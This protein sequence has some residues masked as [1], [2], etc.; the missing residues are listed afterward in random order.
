MRFHLLT[1]GCPKNEVDSEGMIK[2]LGQAGHAPTDRPARADI[3]IVNTCGFIDAAI[4]EST[5]ALKGFAAGKRP[6]Q[7][8][9]AAG[10]LAQRFADRLRLDVPAIDAIV[11]TRELERIVEVAARAHEGEKAKRGK[12][13]KEAVDIPHPTRV[14]PST[15]LKIADG[16]NASCA[17]CVIPQIKG[18]YLS[19]P[20]GQVV[21][22]AKRLTQGGAQELVLI[23]QDTT[24]Y[25][26]D[27]RERDALAGLI[28]AILTAAPG[29]A[30]LR[31]MY[32]YPSAVT[33]QLI[34]VM[35]RYPQVCHY[36][37]LPLQHAHP[38]TLKRMRRP[39]DMSAVRS[40]IRRLREAM[41]DIAIR[42]SFI[43]GFPGETEAEFRSL[44]EFV[45]ETAFDRLGVF[46]YS[47]QEGTPAASLPD[48]VPEAEKARR[49]ERTMELQQ[50][51]SL[52]R[53]RAQVGRELDVLVE[54]VAEA[55]NGKGGRSNANVFN[56]VGRT[57]RDA[58]EVDG[59]IFCQGQAKPGQM[60]RV[61]VTEAMEYDLLGKIVASRSKSGQTEAALLV[62]M[63]G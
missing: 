57:Y 37:D 5:L 59:L 29:L 10:C 36:L 60:V 25:G 3:L 28:P 20:A 41:P 56:L 1:L 7:M 12:A 27:R 49:Y 21:E 51:I 43:V 24:A 31:I 39:S 48:Q 62:K 44:L 13:K 8:L 4:E 22:E 18:P 33:D 11:G 46:T 15:Y 58:P 23:A 14:G 2:L 34:E 50:R 40:L 61:K 55:V 63:K 47:G 9:V 17:F 26:S 54:G 30:W 6:G 16:C 38:A 35:A 45:E 53:N 19:K 52:A 42:T 32:T